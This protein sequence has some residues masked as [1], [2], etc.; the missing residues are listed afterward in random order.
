[1]PAGKSI[2]DARVTVEYSAATVTS[3]RHQILVLE[4]DRAA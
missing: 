1:M 4:V 3:P 2:D